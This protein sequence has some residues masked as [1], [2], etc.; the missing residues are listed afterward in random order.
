MVAWI[1][2]RIG[3]VGL[4]VILIGLIGAYFRLTQLGHQILIDDEWH[5]IHA[6]IRL[7]Y[8]QIF[9]SFGH[10]DHSIPLT[11]FF[12]ALAET[13]GL[14]EWRMR[15]FPMM[16]GLITIALVPWLLRPWLRSYEPWVLAL[17]IALSPILIHF[18]RYVR[19]YAITIPLTFAAVIALWRWWHE[20]KREWLAVFIPASVLAGWMHPLTLLFTGGGLLWFGLVS[21]KDLLKN[22]DMSGLMRVV[23]PGLVTVALS[24]ALVLPPL[25]ADPHSMAAKTGVHQ[26]QFTTLVRAWEL[27]AGVAHWGVAGP[28]LVLAVVGAYILWVREKMFVLYWVFLT[29]LAFVTVVLL[30]PAW[31]HHALVP[32]RYLSIA[33]P[34]VLAL[35]AIGFVTVVHWLSQYNRP[36]MTG[37]LAGGV[38]LAW[39]LGLLSVG[40]HW[41]T[42]G[43]FNQFAGHMRYHFDYDFVRNPFSVVV[44]SVEMPKVYQ[45][46][47]D[48]PGDWTLIEAPWRFE[49]HY[50]PFS[51]FQRQHQM[52]IKIGMLNGLCAD[53]VV[54]E[55]PYQDGE[56]EFRFS[57]FVHLADVPY[58]L[59][60]QNHFVVIHK[61]DMLDDIRAMPDVGR[62][63]EGL[64][65]RL[66]APWYEDE[67]RVIYQVRSGLSESLSSSH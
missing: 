48:E 49:S 57:Q 13:V 3:W 21:L 29:T 22:R 47:K 45:A 20:G 9:L 43:Q 17:L 33:I 12:K 31:V 8:Q 44:D 38:M 34:W 30:N 7:D 16:G 60:D 35:I 24:S 18:S 15:I 25:L 64:G 66:G 46:M 26:L 41:A 27:V 37:A 51:G 11:L 65:D 32:V 23:P 59:T 4:M 2:Q 58:V 52:P 54:G 42:Y 6:L 61:E 10:A 50:T 67:A 14:T 63:I 53:W 5:A 55:L 62:C 19:P 39:F 1:H 36:M 28:M 56:K 40:P